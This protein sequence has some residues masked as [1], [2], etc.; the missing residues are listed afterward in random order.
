MKSSP[1]IA[2]LFAVLCLIS[3]ARLAQA[4]LVAFYPFDNAGDPT[5]DQ[6]GN[7]TPLTATFGAPSYQASGGYEGGAYHFS[8]SDAFQLN[9]NLNSFTNG[10]TVGGWVNVDS[11]LSS[12]QYKWFG[13]DNGGFDPV[14]GL[15]NRDPVFNTDHSFRFTTFTGTT[16]PNVLRGTP[17]YVADQWVFMAM[18]F[19]G[20]SSS[21]GT[22]T[23]Y[24][25]TDATTHGDAV[26]SFASPASFNGSL[27][28]AAIGDISS[29]ALAEGWQG[30]VDNVFVFNQALDATQI[31]S[32]RDGGE[33]AIL[34]IPEVSTVWSSIGLTGVLFV[35]TLRQRRKEKLERL[36]A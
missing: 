16:S 7:N 5:A 12:G 34:A 14:L 27:S 3:A 23:F 28:T 4:D 26:Q 19:T 32:I 1:R 21:S 17:G 2:S 35:F 9:L 20:S 11:G 8:G 18:T 36:A 29:S 6:S 13:T 10:F 15:D 33:E 22:L 31:A 25:D 30:S 24:I